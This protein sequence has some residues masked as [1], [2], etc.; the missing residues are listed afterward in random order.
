[1]G[2]FLEKAGEDLEEDCL[3]LEDKLRTCAPDEPQ[4]VEKLNLYNFLLSESQTQ[5]KRAVR[6]LTRTPC[7]EVPFRAPILYNHRV[8]IKQGIW[9]AENS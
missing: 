4:S 5:P 2:P 9:E 7:S 1:M 6:V 3:P 8:S